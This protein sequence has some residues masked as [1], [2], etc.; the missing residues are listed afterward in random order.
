MSLKVI[1]LLTMGTL[2]FGTRF[3][4]AVLSQRDAICIVNSA[5]G[6]MNPCRVKR[7]RLTTGKEFFATCDP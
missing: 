7:F 6:T 4:L 2:T 1:S 5:M 3:Q